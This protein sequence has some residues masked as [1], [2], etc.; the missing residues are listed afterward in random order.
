MQGVPY[1]GN[2]PRVRI[3]ACPWTDPSG[4]FWPFG[5]WPCSMYS[6]ERLNDLWEYLP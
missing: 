5:G 2:S 6:I 4:N 3:W 1:A